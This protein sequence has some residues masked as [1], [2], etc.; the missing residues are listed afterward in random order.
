MDRGGG[1][2]SVWRGNRGVQWARC[3]VPKLDGLTA[4]KGAYLGQR[5]AGSLVFRP[6]KIG[7]GWEIL[8]EQLEELAWSARRRAV[9]IFPKLV[10]IPAPAH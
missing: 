6:G 10:D 7:K 4:D 3:D 2:D 8:G 9:E 1:A 5:L